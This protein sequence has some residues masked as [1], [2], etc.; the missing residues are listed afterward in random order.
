VVPTIAVGLEVAYADGRRELYSGDAA[1]AEGNAPL[2][3]RFPLVYAIDAAGRSVHYAYDQIGGR[4]YLREVAFDSGLSRYSFD[5]IASASGIQKDVYGYAQTSAQLVGRMVASQNGNVT[6]QWC[7]A[8]AG[9]DGNGGTAS[10]SAPGC[11]VAAPAAALTG[12]DA[13]DQLALIAQSGATASA[14]GPVL[15]FA[16]SAWDEGNRN[17]HDIVYAAPPSKPSLI[18]VRGGRQI[19]VDSTYRFQWADID[20][21]GI[22]DLVELEDNEPNFYVWAGGGSGS[23]AFPFVAT[24]PRSQLGP[25]SFEASASL[26]LDLNDDGLADVLTTTTSDVGLAWSVYLNSTWKDDSGAWN[27]N[28]TRVDFAAPP[29]VRSVTALLTDHASFQVADLNGDGLPD[30]SW[31]NLGQGFACNYV[32]TG[33]FFQHPYA[34]PPA[35]LFGDSTLSDPTCGPG[36]RT[37]LPPSPALPDRGAFFIDVNGDGIRDYVVYGGTA[38]QLVVAYGLGDLRFGPGVALDLN[39]ALPVGNPAR[40]ADID[41]DGQDEILISRDPS[42]GGDLVIDFN[43]ANQTELPPAG[44]LVSVQ[45]N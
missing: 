7:F 22:A 17:A 8:Y 33:T 18:V 30:F 11:N 4:S 32:N 13:H 29:A 24:V 6:N 20:G 5:L 9:P 10:K 28:F 39:A 15:R 44:A 2:V 23:A 14:A 25:A 1:I 16:Y 37:A 41:G 35:L 27:V 21:D 40:V 26:F 38:R 19:L 36:V 34:T 42:F 12:H 31:R 45:T 43:R 3:T